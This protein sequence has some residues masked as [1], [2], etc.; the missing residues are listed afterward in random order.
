MEG[1]TLGQ[2][3]L[4][5]WIW[6][7]PPFAIVA[8]QIAAKAIDRDFYRTWLH[9]EKGI[10]ENLTVLFLVVAI[11]TAVAAFRLRGRVASRWFGPLMLATAAGCFFFAGEELSWGQ[12]W[13]GFEPPEY[14]SARNEQG[15]FNLH[16]DPF[17]ETVLDQLPRLLLTLAAFFGGL[18]APLVRRGR[19][20]DFGSAGIWGWVWPSSVCLP[21]AAFASFV[22]WPE[23]VFELIGGEDSV[24]YLFEISAGETKEF[25]LALFLMVYLL[26]L[27]R[28]VSRKGHVE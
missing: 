8:I 10:V 20:R 16:N 11:V 27:L 26:S 14:V 2:R 23:K 6:L 25:C 13:L 15:E 1:K 17:L 12:H 21:A 22:S 4:P 18:V 24:P 7:W 28:A 5:T 3:E 9:G 19:E